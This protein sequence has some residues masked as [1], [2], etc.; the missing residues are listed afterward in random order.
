MD[1]FQGA[2]FG[3]PE[4]G[5]EGSVAWLCVRGLASNRRCNPRGLPHGAAVDVAPLTGENRSTY[6]PRAAWV[7]NPNLCGGIEG[8]AYDVLT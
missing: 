5:C 6:V 7:D 4:E 1:P 3:E 8:R 2:A